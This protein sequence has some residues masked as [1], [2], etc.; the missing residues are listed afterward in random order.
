M[1]VDGPADRGRFRN[2][3]DV[4]PHQSGED[5]VGLL[6]VPDRAVPGH[7][8][9]GH[10]RGAENP[11][12]QRFPGPHRYLLVIGAGCLVALQS[13][14]Q[15]PCSVNG[16]GDALYRG[17]GNPTVHQILDSIHEGSRFPRSVDALNQDIPARFLGGLP[18]GVGWG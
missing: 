7:P 8:G 14:F 1:P 10:S 6:P 2:G 16:A 4:G 3:R 17:R 9:N 12:S 13:P 18:L 5:L 11:E 15:V